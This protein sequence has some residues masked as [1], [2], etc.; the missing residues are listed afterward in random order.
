[1]LQ[2]YFLIKNGIK[3]GPYSIEQ[4]KSFK[5]SEHDLIWREGLPDWVKVSQLEE[6][7]GYLSPK[8][9]KSPFEKEFI[10]I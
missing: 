9:P 7:A 2:K 10:N 5:L 8:P 3:Y 4:L 1:M 6:V